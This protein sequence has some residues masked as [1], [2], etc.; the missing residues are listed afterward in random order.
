MHDQHRTCPEPP[1]IDRWD[2]WIWLV[3]A[4]VSTVFWIAIRAELVPATVRFAIAVVFCALGLTLL[5]WSSW[6]RASRSNGAVALYVNRLHRL[7]MTAYMA[8]MMLIAGVILVWEPP[9]SLW[10][11][12]LALTPAIPACVAGWQVLQSSTRTP[13]LNGARS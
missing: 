6:R 2:G 9:L 5:L 12:I 3:V 7:A 10:F 4:A 1:R 8:T 11:I 13:P